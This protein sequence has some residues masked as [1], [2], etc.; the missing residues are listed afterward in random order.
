MINT[1]TLNHANLQDLTVLFFKPSLCWRSNILSH[2][3]DIRY[4]LCHFHLLP[5]P[6]LS[7]MPL[8][9]E[10]NE[11]Q[12][13][14]E[15]EELPIFD[16]LENVLT[17][18]RKRNRLPFLLG[19]FISPFQIPSFPSSSTSFSMPSVIVLCIHLGNDLSLGLGSDSPI[20]FTGFKSGSWFGTRSWF[21][22]GFHFGFEN[23]HSVRWNTW[24]LVWDLV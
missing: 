19:R 3:N 8:D 6:Q 22:R 13:Q 17:R 21:E 2:H 9:N 5:S 10:I 1:T 23:T 12:Q 4:H 14:K 7:L 15:Q 16:S 24:F 20:F 11:H 18:A